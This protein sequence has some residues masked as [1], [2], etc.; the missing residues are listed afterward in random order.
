MG[1]RSQVTISITKKAFNENVGENIKDFKDCDLIRQTE[2]TVTFI[3]EHVKWYDSYDDV[4]SVMSVLEKIDE[5]DYG[6]I[7]VGEDSSD[8]E[9]SGSPSE[10]SMY[11]AT[12]L[13]VD[14]AGEDVSH[15][16]FFA[17][18][19]IKFITEE[20]KIPNPAEPAGEAGEQS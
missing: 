7:R 13:E 9:S 15:E 4:K 1:Y 6:L 18:N 10:F 11:T 3:W 5:E 20:D 12:T 19:S 17:P 14:D 2:D 16:K 8:I